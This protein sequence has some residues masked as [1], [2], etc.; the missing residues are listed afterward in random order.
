M[1]RVNVISTKVKH[2]NTFHPEIQ[3]RISEVESQNKISL[4]AG[5]GA[6][7][8]VFGNP[9][10][11]NKSGYK[12]GTLVFSF[13]HSGYQTSDITVLDQR[14][15][16]LNIKHKTLNGNNQC[17][18][19]T[20]VQLFKCTEC[21][22]QCGWNYMIRHV[23]KTHSGKS[24]YVCAYCK[25]YCMQKAYLDSHILAN[26]MYSK[27][28]LSC[29]YCG[30]LAVYESNLKRHMLKHAE[31]SF[32]CHICTFRTTSQGQL[33]KHMNVHIKNVVS[34]KDTC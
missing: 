5:R 20:Q 7:D 11:G 17:N 14:R 32:A 25:F 28:L 16:K 9:G 24:M 10:T 21:D 4:L 22:F 2:K 33:D 30:Y 19:N 3:T 23:R 27:A 29:E 26:H 18:S 12:K 1:D 15:V 31:K 34:L 13:T 6:F 8:K